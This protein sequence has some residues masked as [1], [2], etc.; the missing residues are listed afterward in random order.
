MIHRNHF[1][2]NSM[3][4]RACVQYI[5]CTSFYRLQGNYFIFGYTPSLESG[6]DG[7]DDGEMDVRGVAA[8]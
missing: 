3:I 6:E 2:P 7:T 8:G 1:I 4:N 5:L